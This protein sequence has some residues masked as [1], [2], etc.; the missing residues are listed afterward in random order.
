MKA[1][2][3]ILTILFSA[4][5]AAGQEGQGSITEQDLEILSAATESE[6]EDDS[7]LQQLEHYKRNPLVLNNANADELAELGMLSSLQIQQFLSYRNL[8]GALIDVYELQGIPGWDITTIKKILPYIKI[9]GRQSM[10][11][12]IRERWWGGNNFFLMRFARVL[13]KASGYETRQLGQVNYYKG[14]PDKLFFRYGYNYKNQLQW[15]FL[16]DK[17]PGEALFRGAQKQGF[18]FYSF[19]FF[20]RDAG[21]LK[22]LALGDFT[23]NFGQGLIQWQSLDFRKGAG[24]MNI[25]RQAT[26]LRPYR[27]AGEYN[28]QRGL[29][30]TMQN[31][32]WSTTLFGSARKISG[33]NIMTDTSEN[34]AGFSSFQT[35]GYH[36]TPAEIADRNSLQQYASGG[37]LQFNKKG[38]HFGL[39]AMYYHFSKPLQKPAEPYNLFALSGTD[40]ANGSFDYGITHKNLHFFGEL[41]SDRQLNKAMLAGM[42]LS[43]DPAV[44]FSFL[45]RNIHPAYQSVNASAFTE[46]VM[47]VNE[48]GLYAGIAVRPLLGVRIDA[49]ADV[50]KFP[51]LKYR[52]D[53]PA[54][55]LENFIQITYQPSRTIEWYGRIKFESRA[56]TTK[57][58][59]LAIKYPESVPKEQLRLHTNFVVN[60]R[61]TLRHRIELL[62]FD[63][64]GAGKE[65]GFLSYLECFY[66][67]VFRTTD[68]NLRVQYFETS[69][70]NSRV[71]AYENDLAY[72]FSIPFFYETGFRYYVNFNWETS[73]RKAAINRNPVT[74]K[75]WCKWGQLLYP[76]KT[77]IGSGLETINC[78]KKTELKLQIALV[79]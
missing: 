22:V 34:V 23:V 79:W 56:V 45:Y 77:S 35:S 3:A 13:E 40:F 27:S 54:G 18:D 46:N 26:T 25:K 42:V 28:F 53:A 78:N 67:N 71:Y 74:L 12:A 20:L 15:G 44:D 69:G 2:P 4:L 1:L 68:I 19:H 61:L 14:N 63:R 6:T 41:A 47:P 60:P 70:Y 21:R 9:A 66:R 8:V 7:Y 10:G 16:G 43:L 72:T 57:A 62:W 76:G 50:F 39:N 30:I 55:G 75:C 64:K 49:Y 65:E 32:N 59:D 36:R 17:D 73:L 51:W 29:G 58:A 38:L 33:N 24:I 52:V 31:G 48:K 37:N 11:S 5:M